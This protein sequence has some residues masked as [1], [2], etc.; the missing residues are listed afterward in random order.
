M[1]FE[2]YG[3]GYQYDYSVQYLLEYI[4]LKNPSLNKFI[5]NYFVIDR[6]W[7]YDYAFKSHKINRNT[8]ARVKESSIVQVL[9]RSTWVAGRDGK[10]YP[11]SKVSESTIAD[12]WLINE[13]NGFLHTIG[14]G[15]EQQ[16][17]G[18]ESQRQED[19]KQVEREFDKEAAYK[20]GFS[21]VEDVVSAKED[22]RMV[23]ELMEMGIDV[24]ELYNTKKKER[25]AK[26]YSVQDQ[27][28]Q[29]RENEFH[30][31]EAFDD[32]E[33]YLVKAP[34][35]QTEK[36]KKGIAEEKEPEIKTGISKRAVINEDEK[37]KEKS[38]T[39]DIVHTVKSSTQYHTGELNS[40]TQKSNVAII[41][42]AGD[43]CPNCG[44]SNAHVSVFTMLGKRGTKHMVKGRICKCGI[45]YFTKKQG[46][47]LP[48]DIEI[49]KVKGL[50]PIQEVKKKKLNSSV[51]TKRNKKQSQSSRK[52][53]T[54]CCK[55]HQRTTLFAGT[56]MCW[57]CYKEEMASRFE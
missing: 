2:D 6:N 8:S 34:E 48:P 3:T 55:C 46:N 7:Q 19:L 32:G 52:D 11:P 17:K 50:A 35:Q 13:D 38:R 40:N 18:T 49:K 56:G 27:L 45:K 23:A 44:R 24:R 31:E 39:E 53:G 57:P 51:M 15:N 21:S 1:R 47:K 25:I 37:Q 12:G 20:L 41:V 43:R 5:W 16:A 10:L 33:S 30:A 26:K 22:S 29:M 42:Q 14:F 54:M 36:I 9:K 28:E 4:K